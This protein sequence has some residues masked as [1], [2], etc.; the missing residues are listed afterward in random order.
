MHPECT[1]HYMKAKTWRITTFNHV[2]PHSQTSHDSVWIQFFL[3][4]TTSWNLSSALSLPS[5]V[6][7]WG[8]LKSY[9]VPVCHWS[10]PQKRRSVCRSVVIF[11]AVTPVSDLGSMSPILI[12]CLG[13]WTPSLNMGKLPF[14]LWSLFHISIWEVSVRKK[15]KLEMQFILLAYFFLIISPLKSPMGWLFFNAFK[16]FCPVFIAVWACSLWATLWGPEP[17]IL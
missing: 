3:F 1:V 15:K 6:F 9:L 16:E 12:G 8:L 2:V 11:S 17:E 13:L 14:F 4:F 10:G 5:T 7:L